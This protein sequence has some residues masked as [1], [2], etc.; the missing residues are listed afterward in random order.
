VTAL[1][2]Q[3]G[4]INKSLLLI[5]VFLL[6][7]GAVIVD[8]SSILFRYMRLTDVADEA[9]LDAAAAYKSSKSERTAKEAAQATIASQDSQAQITALDV[10][11][12]TGEVTLTLMDT[13]STLVV[14]RIGFLEHYAVLTHT[15]TSGPPSA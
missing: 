9:S 3:R 11:P 8:G 1:R 7:V 4:L 15:S 2:D 6:V 5:I 10:D 12:R 13:A 14:K